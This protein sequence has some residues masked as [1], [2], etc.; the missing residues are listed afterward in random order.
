MSAASENAADRGYGFVPV[1]RDDRQG[2]TAQFGHPALGRSDVTVE[3][4]DPVAACRTA[5]DL[6]NRSA[7]W[8]GLDWKQPS[9]VVALAQ[10][11]DVDLWQRTP[12]GA[13]TSALPVPGRFTDV[14]SLAG[15]AATRGEDLVL[16]LR[17][18][19]DAS[20]PTAGCGS[21]RRRWSACA[22]QRNAIR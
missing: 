4:E 19:L 22:P 3:A 1:V 7:A 6:A 17:I 13:D 20:V 18:M 10:G 9:C 11:A 8:R 15:Y 2:H 12:G 5:I 16:Q 14:A 21:T